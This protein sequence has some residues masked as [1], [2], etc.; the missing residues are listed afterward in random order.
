LIIDF[1]CGTCTVLG[2]L[3]AALGCDALGIE[4]SYSRCYITLS[5]LK[6]IL[7]RQRDDISDKDRIDDM[8]RIGFVPMNIH[9][10][11]N[12]SFVHELG[13]QAILVF[14]GDEA[15]PNDLMNKT[16]DLINSTHLSTLVISGKQARHSRK[17]DGWGDFWQNERFRHLGEIHWRKTGSG[18]VGKNHFYYRTQNNQVKRNDTNDSISQLLKECLLKN[19]WLSNATYTQRYEWIHCAESI[20][21][22]ENN[23]GISLPPKRRRKPRLIVETN[24]DD[25]EHEY[26]E[27]AGVNE[28]PFVSSN[29]ERESTEDEKALDS[30]SAV[31]DET[32]VDEN[33]VA[34]DASQVRLFYGE[35]SYNTNNDNDDDDDDDDDDETTYM[36]KHILDGLKVRLRYGDEDEDD[37]T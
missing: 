13:Y 35:R 4:Y 20:I 1:G 5:H 16:A 34:M 10:I 6:N 3:S 22:S 17:I 28:L 36:V 33:E 2:S 19:G 12:L 14:L 32:T 23:L 37:D 7:N 24:L 26:N 27:N 11:P 30:S 8:F 18:E 15:F 9:K 31:E 25:I 29:S 21:A